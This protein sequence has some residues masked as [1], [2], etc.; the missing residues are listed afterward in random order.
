[1]KL[2]KRPGCPLCRSTKIIDFKKG[3]FDPGKITS[4]NFNIT[5]S[6]YG[7]TWPL[8]SCKACG[9]VFSNPYAGEEE[10]TRFYSMIEDREYSSETEGRAKNFKTILRRLNKIRKPGNKLLDIGAASG[11]FLHLAEQEGY[12]I[13]GIEPSQFLVQ[14]AQRLFGIELFQGTIADFRSPEKF[15]VITLLDILEHLPEPAEFMKQL[16]RFMLEDGIIVIVTPD[17]NSFAAR[18]TG[19][20]WWHYRIAHVDFFNLASLRYLLADCGYRIVLKKRYAWNF[21][22][23][24]LVTRIFPSLKDKKALQKILKRINFKL[25]LFDSW[26]IY[27]RK[28]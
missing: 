14:E 16:D 8:S 27:A 20:R 26:E 6:N 9:F 1:M 5:D 22:L 11:I 17:I 28:K 2:Q 12:E 23:F 25:Q 3:T 13:S 24:Y 10:L 18:L 21:S 19:R 7:A 15:A 4:E